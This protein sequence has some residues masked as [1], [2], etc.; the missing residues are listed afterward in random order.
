MSGCVNYFH[1]AIEICMNKSQ[2]ANGRWNFIQFNLNLKISMMKVRQV[3]CFDDIASQCCFQQ[4]TTHVYILDAHTMFMRNWN[5][6]TLKGT[7]RSS[8]LS[9]TE[10]SGPLSSIT[11]IPINQRY[12]AI[13]TF[14]ATTKNKKMP[15]CL[16]LFHHTQMAEIMLRDVVTLYR[17]HASMYTSILESGKLLRHFKLRDFRK[18]HSIYEN[19]NSRK[20]SFLI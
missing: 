12:V 14:L 7:E 13:C 16:I 5:N 10:H 2:K 19:K 3:G 9:P 1:V 15:L 18:F 11:A 8:D 17:I 6:W 20:F 4:E